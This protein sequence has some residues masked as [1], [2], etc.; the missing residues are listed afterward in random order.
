MVPTVVQ[1]PLLLLILMVTVLGLSPSISA[2]LSL[3]MRVEDGA[4]VMAPG[5]SGT[6][7]ADVTTDTALPHIVDVTIYYEYGDE[8][9]I[10]RHH[11][12]RFTGTETFSGAISLTSA[13]PHAQD[14][15]TITFT[16]HAED[17]SLY[18]P[19]EDVNAYRSL[20]VSAPR[21]RIVENRWE[22]VDDELTGRLTLENSG[23]LVADRFDVIVD[24]T[25]VA[26]LGPLEVDE[27]REFEFRVE[28]HTDELIEDIKAGDTAVHINGFGGPKETPMTVKFSSST[29]GFGFTFRTVDMGTLATVTIWS[30]SVF[31]FYLLS[32]GIVYV[33]FRGGN[34]HDTDPYPGLLDSEDTCDHPLR[35]DSR[36]VGA[37][38]L[39][40][41]THPWYLLGAFLLS[42]VLG[43]FVGVLLVLLP[44]RLVYHYLVH[45][46]FDIALVA[47]GLRRAVG[48]FDQTEGRMPL[49]NIQSCSLSRTFGDRIFGTSTLRVYA[50]GTNEYTATIPAYAYNEELRDDLDSH[51]SGG[52]YDPVAE[53]TLPSAPPEPEPIDVDGVKNLVTET[54]RGI[55]LHI[56]RKAIFWHHMG[57][58][59]FEVGK[60]A[61]PLALL[62]LL[63]GWSPSP[64]MLFTF[65]SIALYW[66]W[67]AF[68]CGRLR[69]R[70]YS[71]NVTPVLVEVTEGDIGRSFRRI[72]YTRIQG[73]ATWWTFLERRSEVKNLTLS[74]VGGTQDEDLL[75]IPAPAWLGSLL[76][77]RSLM[78]AN[79]IAKT[80]VTK[81]IRNIIEEEALLPKKD[82]RYSTPVTGK[83]ERTE[84]TLL[85]I[86]PSLFLSR[87]LHQGTIAGYFVLVGYF[88]LFMGWAEPAI[89]RILGVALVGFVFLAY[90]LWYQRMHVL[91][92]RYELR[93]DRA[94]H[95]SGVFGRRVR[96]YPYSAM[97]STTRSQ[98]LVERE[99]GIETVTMV[100]SS[101]V[102][103]FTGTRD[104]EGLHVFFQKYRGL[105]RKNAPRII[106]PT[107]T[108]K[109]ILDGMRAGSYSLE[110]ARIPDV[111]GESDIPGIDPQI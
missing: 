81:D 67:T 98:D 1:R 80:T 70:N 84:G 78:F 22:M 82:P 13:V 85:D 99:L 46:S 110:D 40:R 32:F 109:E 106:E 34:G 24:G 87:S 72:H 79:T 65:V 6:I 25:T 97:H 14:G 9:D 92:T 4:A 77:N 62:I 94:I 53:R 35:V 86:K 74:T 108:R 60:Y 101:G 20:T 105:A 15:G 48:I 19:G 73:M 29:R 76:E 68:I 59:S 3:D 39:A 2:G 45:R 89:V 31:L 36:Y 17:H 100:T 10:L 69:A 54:D 55:E 66:T 107:A 104:P 43:P 42:Y 33:L 49:E 26:T 103:P 28:N 23:S 57:E 16:T 41:I 96:W 18:N 7:T 71:V 21:L 95:S 38:D 37:A 47:G 63:M 91:G 64:L 11:T 102:L 12:M 90:H 83:E 61:G 44:V 93:H 27:E 75:G 50:T 30:V 58:M 52:T 88:L 56:D 111:S 5:S 8:G 51:I